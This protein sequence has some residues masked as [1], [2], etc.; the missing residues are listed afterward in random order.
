M[1]VCAYVCLSAFETYECAGSFH[2]YGSFFDVVASAGS[3]EPDP[4]AEAEA[5]AIAAVLYL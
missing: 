5:L 1:H 2:P 4:E 3:N